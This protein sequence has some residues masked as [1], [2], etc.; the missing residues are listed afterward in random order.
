MGHAGQHRCTIRK[1]G[2][3][4]KHTLKAKGTAKKPKTCKLRNSITPGTVLILIAG[5]FRGKRCVFLKQ[6]ES[7]LL[8]VTGPYAVNG[9]PLR[10][11]NQRYCIAT[12][13][14]LDLKGADCSS[15]TD[16]YFKK[17]EDKKKQKKKSEG[18]FFAPET[19]KKAISEEKKEGQKKL[20][21][22][23][24]GGLDQTTKL[25]LRSL[26]SLSEK[27]YPHEMKF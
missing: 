21:A 11:V 6:L 25:Y 23:L 13:T 7:G 20:D 14:K 18:G 9:I 19:E 4:K 2:S 3:T 22:P 27:T 24:V 1:Y 8:L 5:R 16:T 26:F 12:S 15:I 10:R 17:E